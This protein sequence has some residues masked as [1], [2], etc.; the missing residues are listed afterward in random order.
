[1]ENKEKIQINLA[2]GMERVE[3]VYR[4]GVATKELEQKP[5]VQTNLEGNEY[6][7]VCPTTSNPVFARFATGFSI[8]I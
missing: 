1:M 8:P 6:N 7:M 3:V 2:P 4:E 5:P